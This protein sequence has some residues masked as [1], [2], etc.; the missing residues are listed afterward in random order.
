MNKELESAINE[1]ID[2]HNIEISDVEYNCG[3]IWFVNKTTGKKMFL[4]F[5]EC[6]SEDII[7]CCVCG[8]DCIPD[9]DCLGNWL[10]PDKNCSVHKL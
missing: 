3:S 1:A 10:C 7:S 4:S 5:G 6:E 8:K 9:P 2:F